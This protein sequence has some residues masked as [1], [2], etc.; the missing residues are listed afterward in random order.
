MLPTGPLWKCKLW[1]ANHPTKSPLQLFYRD[2]IEC[3][4]SL[5]NSPLSAD[6]IEFTPYKLYKTAE[7]SIRVYSE[8][9]SG[10][11]AWTMQV[12]VFLAEFLYV[13]LIKVFQQ[14]IPPKATLLG[15]ILS[16]DKTRITAM[17]GD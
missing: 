6:D 8:W 5:L 7:K 12:C 11:V 9:L 10:D 17:T 1:A 16:S 2:P 13:V 14:N 4:E 15:T 3:I